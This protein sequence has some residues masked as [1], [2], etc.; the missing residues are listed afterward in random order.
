MHTNPQT[1]HGKFEHLADGAQLMLTSIRQWIASYHLE[2]CGCCA[3]RP[4]YKAYDIEGAL[5]VLNEMMCFLSLAVVKEL[6]IFSPVDEDVSEDE[7][8]ILRMI[9]AVEANQPHS[10]YE[11]A[12]GYFPPPVA[13]TFF[14]ICRCMVDHYSNGG[15]VFAGSTKLRLV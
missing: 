6:V 9:K 11:H 3:L 4:Q 15:L 7:A 1:E 13:T 14:R 12:G 5:P 2:E 8:A 10:A